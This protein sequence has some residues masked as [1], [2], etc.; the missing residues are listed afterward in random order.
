[1]KVEI[2]GISDAIREIED[3]PRKI[4]RK[5]VSGGLRSLGKEGVKDLKAAVPVD[6]GGT[7]RS[8]GSRVLKKRGDELAA[9]KIG[10]TK[11][12]EGKKRRKYNSAF[13]G[14]TNYWVAHEHV[15]RFL[16]GGVQRHVLMAWS[17]TGKR[18][19]RVAIRRM[20]RGGAIKGKVVYHKGFQG[21]YLMQ[22]MVSLY[23]RKY[24]QRFAE[25]LL[26][27]YRKAVA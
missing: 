15:L 11:S 24:A 13:G 20:N 18:L 10:E 21:R 4:I 26:D 19:D 12:R 16:D 23:G 22:Q 9:I 7:R 1:M 5:G 25:G 6:T 27:A 14:M 17:A 3:Q 8:I 2:E